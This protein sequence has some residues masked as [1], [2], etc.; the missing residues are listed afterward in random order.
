LFSWMQHVGRDSASPCVAHL[1]F[2]SLFSWMQHVGPESRVGRHGRRQVS[3]L[4]LLD[5]ARRPLSCSNLL[6]FSEIGSFSVRPFHSVL[7]SESCLLNLISAH[8]R[9]VLL[10][11]TVAG[12]GIA[13]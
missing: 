2:R 1:G 7:L 9:N 4:V 6:S 13:R 10:S 3:I 8:Q 12:L 11:E 5:A